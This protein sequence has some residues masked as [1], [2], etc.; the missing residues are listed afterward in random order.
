MRPRRSRALVDWLSG[1][2]ATVITAH[3]H[4]RHTAS[5]RVAERAGLFPTAEEVDGERAWRLAR[6]DNQLRSQHDGR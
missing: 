2:G 3:I 1:Q 4:P 5:A 6:D